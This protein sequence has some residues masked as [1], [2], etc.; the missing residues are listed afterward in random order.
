MRERCCCSRCSHP[1]ASKR[2]QAKQQEREGKKEKEARLLLALVLWA[3]RSASAVPRRGPHAPRGAEGADESTRRRGRREE[4]S[5]LACGARSFTVAARFFSSPFF[6]FSIL[7]PFFVFSS[8]LR[9]VVDRQHHLVD[10]RVLEG[11]FCG[12]ERGIRGGQQ[13]VRRGRMSQVFILFFFLSLLRSFRTNSMIEFAPFSS[14]E[15]ALD[16]LSFAPHSSSLASSED[17][18]RPDMESGSQFYAEERGSEGRGSRVVVFEKK[19][20][21]ERKTIEARELL[22]FVPFLHGASPELSSAPPLS[23]TLHARTW[24]W[25]MIIGRLAKSTMGLGTVSVRGRRR[26]PNPPTRMSART[27]LF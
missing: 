24:I 5:K 20:E 14:S 23:P 10:A 9:L 8:H 18:P 11:L 1:L 15:G 13:G 7:F 25:W 12:V 21:T 16:N 26:V 6:P 2:E 22:G 3:I 17:A 4:E 19:R 27:I